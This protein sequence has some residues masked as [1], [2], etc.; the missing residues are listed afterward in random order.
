LDDVA[1]AIRILSALAG[2]IALSALSISCLGLHSF[3]HH[4]WT[5]YYQVFAG[6]VSPGN[7]GGELLERFFATW[8]SH[9]FQAIGI[10]AAKH[11]AWS[12]IPTPGLAGFAGVR[13]IVE[14]FL[15]RSLPH[16][17]N[18]VVG[19]ALLAPIFVPTIGW[20]IAILHYLFFR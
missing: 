7:V 11:V 19:L 6:A 1:L 13:P 16:D 15:G 10:I 5:G 2:P 3:L 8:K 9:A 18:L 4:V 17:F 20:T 12:L 14:R